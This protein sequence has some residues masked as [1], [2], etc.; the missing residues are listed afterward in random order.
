MNTQEQLIDTSS[1]DP[2]TVFKRTPLPGTWGRIIFN[3]TEFTFA[4]LK[5]R[6]NT[7]DNTPMYYWSSIDRGEVATSDVMLWNTLDELTIIKLTRY[8]MFYDEQLRKVVVFK[9][10]T[11]LDI[12]DITSIKYILQSDFPLL[13]QCAVTIKALTG[14]MTSNYIAFEFENIHNMFVPIWYTRFNYETLTM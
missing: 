6:N 1:A 3:T 4:Q 2:G 14:S 7:K 12:K 11:E 9:P 8:R 5:T 10:Q 13:D